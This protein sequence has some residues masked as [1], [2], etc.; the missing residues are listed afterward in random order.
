M[1]TTNR[2]LQREAF[3]ISRELEYFTAD[4]LE[5]QTGYSREQW[6]PA[7]IIKEAVDNALDAGEQA[8]IAPEIAVLFEQCKLEIR[9]NG[10]GIPPEI[11]ERLIDYTTRTSDKLAYVSPT[12]GA[13]G[14]GL[15]TLLAIP[16]VLDGEAALPVVIEARGVR[17][18]IYIRADQVARRPRIEHQLLSIQSDGAALSFDPVKASLNAGG[19][20]PGNVPV[21]VQSRGNAIFFERPEASLNAGDVGDE[22]LGNV[23][24]LVSDYALFNPHAAFRLCDERYSYE[25]P[26]LDL[27]WRKWSPRDPTPAHW[28]TPDHFQ[29]LVASCVSTGNSG[30]VRDF[31]VQFRGLARTD[32]RMDVL[33]AAGLP[34]GMK[35]E[36]LA[37]KERGAFDRDALQR[38]LLA[39]Q[40]NSAEVAPELMGVL[41]KKHFLENLPGEDRSFRYARQSGCELGLPYVVEAACRCTADELL[42]GLHVGLNWSVPLSNPL[43]R[44]PLPL[45]DESSYAYSLEGF[46]RH[47]RID[48]DE[49][50]VALV[51]HIVTPRFDFLDRGKG[52]VKLPPSIARAVAETV[53]KVAKE[54]ASIKRHRD[55]EHLRAARRQEELLR[56]GRAAEITVKD[57]AWQAIPDAYLKASGGGELPANARQI[58]Y[59]AR[60]AILEITGRDTL[61]DNYFTQSLLPEY[62]REHPEETAEW[63]VVY[64][65]RGHLLEPHTG[66]R[67]GIGTLAVRDYL[68]ASAQS[69]KAPA[70][71]LPELSFRLVTTGP[72]HRYGAILYIEKEGFLPLLENVGLAERYDLAIMS[73]KGMGSTSARYLIEQLARD[74]RI[75]VLHD[76]DKSGFSIAG[77]LSRDTTRYRFARPP[78]IID[79]GIRL[80]DVEEYSLESEPVDYAPRTD[81]TQN[82]QDNG[83]TD[84]EIAFIV[85][86]LGDDGRYRGRRVELNAFTSDQFVTWLEAKLRLHHVQK[87]IPD[88]M[89]LAESYRRT[90]ALA[91]LERIM[92]QALPDVEQTA[93]SAAV[94]EDLLKRIAE[95]LARDPSAAWDE[96]LQRLSRQTQP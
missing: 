49:D 66:T 23:L 45:S 2:G 8:G 10:G 14:N 12:R 47:L 3:T 5:K 6:W 1:K 51:L 24:R 44:C 15:K 40:Q 73:S 33:A 46:L 9:D 55:R 7:V 85:G 31:L 90:V 36:E 56:H 11:V 43:Q 39:M 52:S 21:S 30:T 75:F 57:A 58:M 86:D 34:R 53:S 79:L 20:K 94:P 96:A 78:E 74:A 17:H 28:Y 93:Q 82:L 92:K 41:G 35:L 91:E 65:D 54:W 50:P 89:T 84:E 77:T 22:I 83:A 19:E 72:R 4:E 48:L 32:T 63:D 61:D 64:D 68:V 70:V 42:Q 26:A 37:D 13:Q 38:L 69:P 87:V 18:E 95:E 16:Y 88:A 29:E 62:M 80:A 71:D 67:I 25:F 81:P 27:K 76:F 59:A 60:P